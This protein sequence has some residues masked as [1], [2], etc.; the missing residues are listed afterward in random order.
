MIDIE[1]AV[2]DKVA[3]ALRTAY[4]TAYP[5]LKVFGEYV[6]LGEKFPTVTIVE[7]DNQ[8]FEKTATIGQKENH[9]EVMYDINVYAND[10]SKKKQTAKKLTATIDAEMLGMGFRRMFFSQV[11][12]IDDSIY[13]INLKY[14]GV[15]SKGKTVGTTI[16]HHISNW[17]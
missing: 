14:R 7:A 5:N 4:L 1:N 11:P 12:N 3:K 17:R 16:T 10:G 15:V 6:P 2:F 13:R 9:A 8:V